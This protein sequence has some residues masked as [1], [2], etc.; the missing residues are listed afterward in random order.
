MGKVKERK[1]KS[2]KFDYAIL[3]SILILVFFTIRYLISGNYEFLTYVVV[4]G[5]VIWILAK[6]NKIFHYSNLAKYGFASWLFL[7]LAGGSF[8]VGGTRLYDLILWPLIGEPYNI[9]RYDQVIHGYCYFIMTLLLYSV[10]V[11]ATRNKASKTMIIT[12]A[13]LSSMGI[14][15]LNEVIE[16]STVAFFGATGV[17]NYWNNA[18]DLVFNLLGCFFAVL[19]VRK[20]K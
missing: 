10:V 13:V 16:F 15:A 3:T 19:I 17:G 6:T 8:K 1:I 20:K 12:L 9:L 18:L 7:H 2:P 4:L 5:L 14:S 11:Y